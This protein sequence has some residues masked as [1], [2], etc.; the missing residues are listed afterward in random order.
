MKS[1]KLVLL[2]FL[3]MTG[4]TT[5]SCSKNPRLYAGGFTKG[6]E[7]GLNVY[8]LNRKT[9]GLTLLSQS[10]AGPN[11]SYFCF[12]SGKNLLYAANEVSEFKG[13]RGG[14]LTTLR[15]DPQTASLEKI[16]EMVIPYG[17]PCYISISPDNGF[18]FVANYPRGSVVV[19]RLNKE[20]IPEAVTDT[21]LY[22]PEKPNA[23]HA[24]MILSDPQG[25]HIYV[26]DLGLDR[27]VIY[28]F[29][30]REGKLIQIE[31]GIVPVAEGS[32]PRHFS[33]SADGS[34][35]YL[36]NE[37]GSTMMAFSNERGKGLRLLQTL[38]TRGYSSVER[39]YCADVHIGES[40]KYIY[41]SNRGENS[42]VVYKI[43]A[44]GTLSLAGHNTC[45]GDWPRNFVID[46]SGEFLLA[47]N[48]RSDNIAVFR[49]NSKT[50]LPEGP[51]N[52]INMKAPACLKFIP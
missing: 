40:G 4:F 37:L 6:D 33:F 30:N 42:I 49:I 16:S 34:K 13:S 9:G 5:T 36:I 48:Q 25:K 24:H 47:G 7:K 52:S 39:N 18:L 44:D 46:P 32:G 19:V 11:P 8:E 27:V 23:S 51:V 1:L 41:G 26:T 2:S 12:S 3:I 38:S 35:M 17:G 14:G 21:I 10:D 20:G 28:N 45:G 29:D 31:N 50:G 43:A 15:Y 22:N